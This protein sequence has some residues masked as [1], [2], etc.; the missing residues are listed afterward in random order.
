MV[1]LVGNG[2]DKVQYATVVVHTPKRAHTHKYIVK[3]VTY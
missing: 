1:N 2:N 3:H